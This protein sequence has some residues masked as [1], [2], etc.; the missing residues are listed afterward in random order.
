M[1]K[2]IMTPNEFSDFKYLNVYTEY[3]FLEICCFSWLLVKISSQTVKSY[4]PQ[5]DWNKKVSS[6]K[7]NKN[8]IALCWVF[9][10][11]NSNI[12]Q[13]GRNI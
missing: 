7:L 4:Q 13:R 10:W 2:Y 6:G 12:G 9:P 5:K 11:H 1:N 3:I 8:A